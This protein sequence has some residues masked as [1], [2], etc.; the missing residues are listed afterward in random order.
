MQKTKE[1]SRTGSSLKNFPRVKQN[2]RDETV[3]VCDVAGK[4]GDTGTMLA[5]RA[6]CECTGV[7]WA[8]RVQ[9]G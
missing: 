1:E 3:M 5:W 6:W 8:G 7:M 2:V 4:G 9:D